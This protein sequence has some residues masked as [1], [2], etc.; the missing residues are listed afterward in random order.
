MRAGRPWVLLVDDDSQI[1]SLCVKIL[2][3][4]GYQVLEADNGEVALT[5]AA[6]HNG[7]IHLLLTDV[8]MPGMNGAELSQAIAA[9]RPETTVLYM[10][11]G[12]AEM[13]RKYVGRGSLL[14]RK[15]FPPDILLQKVRE[16]LN[17]AAPQASQRPG[18]IDHRRAQ[19][20][21]LRAA[22][23]RAH[24]EFLDTCKVYAGQLEEY[25]LSGIPAPDGARLLRT[26]GEAHRAALDKYLGALKTFS[27]FA[28]HRGAT[29]SVRAG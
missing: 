16:A 13:A 12:D 1:R 18:A 11:G 23:D 7:V 3:G 2:S 10:S 6:R 5:I 29:K 9:M 24:R 27:D 19:I 17:G 20:D 4:N 28:D 14:L 25:R 15:P 22:L 26:A 8:L 21:E